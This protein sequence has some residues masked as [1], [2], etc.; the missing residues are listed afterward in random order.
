MNGPKVAFTIPIFGGLNITETLV[1][2][3][4]I[5]AI[6]TAVVLWL[7]HNMQRIPTKK[8]VVAEMIVTAV[9]KMVKQNMGEKHMVYAPYIATI[10]VFSALG[11]LIS[12]IGL[13]PMTADLNV[14]MT[15]ALICFVMITY[16]KFKYNGLFG[17]FKSYAEPVVF[18][19]PLNIISEIATPFSMG[20]RHFGNIAGGMVITS[21][22]Y[23]SLATLSKAIKFDFTLGIFKLDIFQIGIP[24]VLSIYFDLFT[25]FMQAF[26]FIMLTMAYVGG[27]IEDEK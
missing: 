21:L 7:T 15:W 18:M 20:F 19:T 16:N 10:F 22:I 27:T 14:T 23:S 11:S 4:L 17:Y 8:Q 12:L 26:I 9:N 24:A 3:W 5:I 2:G 13:R 25:G 6:I 1:I